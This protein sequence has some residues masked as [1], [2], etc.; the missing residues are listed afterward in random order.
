MFC[1]CHLN[2]PGGSSP[3][4]T[5]EE[6]PSPAILS[7]L[8]H[9]SCKDEAQLGL[10]PKCVSPSLLWF[11]WPCRPPRAPRGEHQVNHVTQTP[12]EG[13]LRV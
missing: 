2:T 11:H 6:D 1:I 12:N 3:S 10:K 8:P 7:I 13:M 4:F 5:D 9:V